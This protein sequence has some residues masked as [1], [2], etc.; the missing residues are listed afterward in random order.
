MALSAA[1]STL[2]PSDSLAI[3]N[4]MP[5]SN[6]YMP[7]LSPSFET[8]LPPCSRMETSLYTQG[9][10][11]LHTLPQPWMTP[12]GPMFPSPTPVDHKMFPPTCPSRWPSSGALE[13]WTVGTTIVKLVLPIP[14]TTPTHR[15]LHACPHPHAH[16]PSR[17]PNGRLM[18]D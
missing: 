7:R 1:R 2:T 13:D 5:C 6:I 18:I 9:P 10:M 4:W 8:W 16:Q 14:A 15:C 12:N 3:G 17:H 11:C